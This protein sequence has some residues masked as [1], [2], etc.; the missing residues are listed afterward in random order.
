MQKIS[1]A[2]GASMLMLIGAAAA[3]PAARTVLTGE[4]ALKTPAD[5]DSIRSRKARSVALFQEAGKVI[6]HPRCLN[7]HVADDRPL[8]GDEMRPHMPYVRRGDAGMGKDGL[9]CT[10]CH[11][12]ANFDPAHIPGHPNWHLAPPEMA[13]V[14]RSLG[15]I[16]LQLKDKARNGGMNMEEMVKHMSSDSLVGWGWNPGSGRTPAP[17]TQEGFGQLI[18][19]W[20][21]T[22]AVCPK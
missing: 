22:G 21:D 19:A 16:C 2:L 6:Q 7:C 18:R 20:V 15:E 9:Y 1:L 11:G 10:T 4:G 17:G 14:G 12:P 3:G 13:W 5:F 8:Q